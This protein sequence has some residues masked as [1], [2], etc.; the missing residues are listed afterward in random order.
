VVA[1]RLSG[2]EEP[3][4][5][6]DATLIG[7]SAEEAGLTG[8]A[9][10]AARPE[11][12]AAAPE[13]RRPAAP[14]PRRRLRTAAKVLVALVIVAAICVG[15]WLGARQIY[16]LGTDEGGRLALYRGLPYDLPLDISLYSEVLSSPVQVASLPEDR[17]DEATNHD[18]RSKDDATSLL[19]DLEQSVPAPPPSPAPGGEAGGQRKGTPRGDRTRDRNGSRQGGNNNP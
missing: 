12:A 18:L 6:E 19:D 10:G 5:D 2:A 11:P 15:A 13:R 3:A 14:P 8:A 1:F 9:V 7:P 16:F 17:H 4:V